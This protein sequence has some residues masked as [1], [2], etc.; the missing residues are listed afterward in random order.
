M[1]LPA[2]LSSDPGSSSGAMMLEYTAHAAAADVR[3]RATPVATLTTTVGGGVESHASFAPFAARLAQEALD[4]A[5]TAIAT[6]LVLAVR[7]LRMR[8]LEPSGTDAGDLFAEAAARLD[9]NL[10]D[11]ALNA[12]V[13]AARRLLFE[14]PPAK[15]C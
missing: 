11:R 10:G 3:V 8:G 13:E 6:E 15:S 9:A 2:A 12:D 5:R 4:S 7:A 1:G 14:E